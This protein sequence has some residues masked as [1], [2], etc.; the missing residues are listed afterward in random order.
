M[1][2]RRALIRSSFKKT[3]SNSL[4]NLETFSDFKKIFSLT[5]SVAHFG[6]PPFRHG[7]FPRNETGK[8]EEGT[9]KGKG[10]E[11]QVSSQEGKCPEKS[12]P[13]SFSSF[14]L[15]RRLSG[16]ESEEEGKGNFVRRCRIGQTFKK[17]T[18][19]KKIP[20][21]LSGFFF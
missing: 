19:V 13:L 8:E 5:F 1:Q 18:V 21:F 9:R 11:K 4:Q 16:A 15:R 2:A 17:I 6:F 12:P 10:G 14:L 7:D 3:F 20:L